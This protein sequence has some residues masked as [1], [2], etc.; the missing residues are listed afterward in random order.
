MDRPSVTE[1][2]LLRA[3]LK[4]IPALL[5]NVRFCYQSDDPF[6]VQLTI[7]C[8]GQ[9]ITW[10][11]SRELLEQGMYAGVGRGDVVVAPALDDDEVLIGLAPAEGSAVLGIDRG[12]VRKFLD[13]TYRLVPEGSE[14]QHLDLDDALAQLLTA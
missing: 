1:S 14:P 8:D 2:E 7:D 4:S 11:F 12:A 3:S 13:A 6:A 10:T 5:F 9:A